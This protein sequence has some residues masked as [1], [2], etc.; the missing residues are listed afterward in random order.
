MSE[1][2]PSEGHTRILLISH[3]A[4]LA[5]GAEHAFVELVDGIR[6]CAP[7]LPLLVVVPK[8]GIIAQRSRLLGADVAIVAQP[9]WADFGSP[10]VWGWTKRLIQGVVSLPSM[11][12]L[13]R[14]WRPD[15]MITNTMTIPV[16]PVAA[17]LCK[18]RNLWM[19]HEY[20]THDH[21]L[22]FGLGYR[23]TVA[24]IGR[25]ADEIVCCSCAVRDM[26]VAQ[27][28]PDNFLKVVYGAVNVPSGITTRARTSN[29]PLNAIL[30]GRIAEGK[31][32]LLAVRAVGAANRA[33]ADV[34]LR[35]VGEPYDPQYVHRVKAAVTAEGLEDR[36]EFLGALDDP[37]PIY[38]DSDV[39]LMCSRNEAFGRV[40][41]EAMKLGIPVI[42]VSSGG[43][44]ELVEDQRTGFLVA[45]DDAASMSAA[46]HTYWI[47]EDLRR[48][49]GENARESSVNRFTIAEW[50]EEILALA[51]RVPD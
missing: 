46:L 24:A 31:G 17:R 23:K 12:F 27:G 16:G 15:V 51:E 19:I 47:D 14:R 21:N 40:T 6:T 41:V 1:H 39:F 8:E 26:M 4:T 45:T 25:I 43:T 44:V 2:P 30:V 20:G 9:R 35:L 10:G 33:G 34:R 18:V 28:L 22:S 13:I 36:V 50:V 3:G 37:F 42:G 48:R 29:S 32:Q 7:S 11:L 5:G 49:M 38:R